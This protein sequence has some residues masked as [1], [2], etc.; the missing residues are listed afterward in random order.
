MTHFY[1]DGKL[2]KFALYPSLLL[3]FVIYFL[4][5]L[6][7]DRFL[8]VTPNR[9]KIILVKQKISKFTISLF[10]SMI[11]MALV[12]VVILLNYQKWFDWSSSLMLF[13]YSATL[14]SVIWFVVKKIEKGDR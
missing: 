11:I 1:F 6:L 9:L 10:I 4:S 2:K 7:T 14:W 5:Y 12:S 8:T 3:I 13:G